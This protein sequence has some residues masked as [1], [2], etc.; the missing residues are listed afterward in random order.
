MF[1]LTFNHVS[2]GYE[3]PNTLSRSQEVRLSSDDQPCLSLV[4][5]HLND[6]YQDRITQF[7]YQLI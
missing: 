4:N 3:A 7:Y 5:C 1:E 2:L 6:T